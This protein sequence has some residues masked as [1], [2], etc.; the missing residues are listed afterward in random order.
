MTPAGTALKSETAILDVPVALCTF[1]TGTLRA[2]CG[3]F[4]D[5][6]FVDSDTNTPRTPAVAVAS[7]PYVF[8]YR[9]L[10]PYFKFTL[11]PLEIDKQENEAWT[12]LRD[13]NTAAAN[14]HEALGVAR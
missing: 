12:E 9:N 4:V 10:R 13:G 8:I 11:P 5:S 3:L 14:A 2:D 6:L 1:Y 7:G